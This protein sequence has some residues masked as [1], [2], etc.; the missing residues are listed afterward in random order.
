MIRKRRRSLGTILLALLFC[1]ALLPAEEVGRVAAL[2]ES[3]AIIRGG[4]PLPG[5][6]E[7]GTPLEAED[8]LLTGEGYGE[9]ILDELGRLRLWPNT[10]VHLRRGG[11]IELLSGTL[12]FRRLGGSEP[13][14]I[15]SGAITL[16]IRSGEAT[17]SA[18]AG[19]LRLVVADSGR[20]PVLSEDGVRRFA[21]PDRPV[22][23]YQRLSNIEDSPLAWSE[24]ALSDF[25]SRGPG[26]MAERF[27]GYLELRDRF[28]AAYEELLLHREVLNRWR[29]DYRR[30]VT[31]AMEETLNGAP[32][33]SEALGA[34]F[35]VGEEMERRYYQLRLDA[36]YLRE[37]FQDHLRQ[38]Q[39]Y[40]P[41]RLH[42]LRFLRAIVPTTMVEEEGA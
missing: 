23:F 40:L 16:E 26:E 20:Q 22:G 17:M 13:V 25:A 32:E 5:A 9:V 1:A 39:A 42:F 7:G 10:V 24:T 8:L 34:A 6:V 41:E 30:G 18:D 35:R 14:P 29:R 36:P 19:D 27:R 37:E 3:V 2:A 28:D 31:S 38:E 15:L 12:R 33:L 11:E 4:E 21:E